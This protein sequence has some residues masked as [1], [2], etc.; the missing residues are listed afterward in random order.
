MA[1]DGNAE[2]ETAIGLFDQA[3]S[4]DGTSST[5]LYLKGQVLW[6]GEGEVDTA[7]D[8]FHEVLADPELSPE[9]RASVVSDLA[10]A[11]DGGACR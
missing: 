1:W 9:A 3:L 8:L 10:T 7:I 11:E 2:A 6:C 4:I 5:A